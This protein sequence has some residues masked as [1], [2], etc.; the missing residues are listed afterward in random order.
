MYMHSTIVKNEFMY[1]ETDA[2]K[3]GSPQMHAPTPRLLELCAVPKLGNGSV[4]ALPILDHARLLLNLSAALSQ[5]R[6]P[7]KALTHA[8][9]RQTS[10]K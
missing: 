2:M 3:L 1:L 7:D 6:A 5:M 10:V 8:P 9:E 4:C